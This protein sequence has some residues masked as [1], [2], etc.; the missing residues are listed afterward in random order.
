[1][2]CVCELSVSVNYSHWST[3]SSTPWGRKF[4]HVLSICLVVVG[5]HTRPFSFS[6]ATSFL[7]C[8]S[9]NQGSCCFYFCYTSLWP[10]NLRFKKCHLCHDIFHFKIQIEAWKRYRCTDTNK[11]ICLCL[12][13]MIRHHYCWC[14]CPCSAPVAMSEIER[15][16]AL[17]M[18]DLDDE[19]LDDGDLD[20]E[21]LLVTHL[22]DTWTLLI[23]CIAY[24][25]HKWVFILNC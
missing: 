17:C 11:C 4:L 12:I 23:S 25:I 1:M 15:M 18:K 16:A 20:D 7:C 5:C 3:H 2:S 6:L 19:D 22:Q 8:S 24:Q 13:H 14:V 9:I 21:D 10:K